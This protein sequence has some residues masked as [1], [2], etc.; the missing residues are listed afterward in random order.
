MRVSARGLAGAQV[1]EAVGEQR[2]ARHLGQ[3]VGD[4]D[5]RQHGV[6]ACG[7]GVD[8]GQALVQQRLAGGDEGVEAGLDGDWQGP[9]LLVRPHG[10]GEDQPLLEGAVLPAAGHPHVAGLDAAAQLRQ[11]AE[12][13]VA[14]VDDA[15]GIT[16]AAQRCLTNPVGTDFGRE[17]RPA[18]LALRSTSMARVSEAHA[19]TPSNWNASRKAGAQPDAGIVLAHA[20]VGVELLRARQRLGF[21]HC[22]AEPLPRHDR[23]D[24]VKGVLLA[25]AGGDQ[26]RA[27]TGIEAHFVVDGAGIGLEGTG[28]PPL[29]FA[30]HRADPAIEQSDGLVDQACGQVQRRGHQRRVPPLPLIA[31]DMLDGGAASLAGELREVGLVDDMAAAGSMPTPRTCSSRS[32]PR[33]SLRDFAEAQ[34]RRWL[35]GLGHLLQPCQ[36]ALAGVLA[37]LRQHVKACQ[38]QHGRHGFR[39]PG[40]RTS[41]AHRRQP[42]AAHPAAGPAFGGCHRWTR[43]CSRLACAGNRI[44]QVSAPCRIPTWFAAWFQRPKGAGSGPGLP[45]T[46]NKWL[47]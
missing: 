33:K 35:G 47:L 16:S 45:T 4:A 5:A 12:L 19:G 29:G 42:T 22:R 46:G 10:I 38:G 17:D 11:D 28:L 24:R 7:Q 8:R 9:G 40:P 21:G 39:W 41:D 6:E 36:P 44:R 37:T 32:I 3:Q 14:P 15:P 27:D 34:H 26:G 30:E 31:R 43:A 25:R 2:P 13:V 23:D 18:R 1:D 20:L